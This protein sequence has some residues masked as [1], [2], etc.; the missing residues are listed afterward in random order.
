MPPRVRL[1]AEETERLSGLL[2]MVDKL[3]SEFPA[4]ADAP[5]QA[6]WVRDRYSGDT[7][8]TLNLVTLLLFEH[9]VHRSVD[10]VAHDLAILRKDTVNEQTGRNRDGA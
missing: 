8:L 10:Q 7:P 9:G 2:G 6:S 4:D 1:S 5:T 3:R